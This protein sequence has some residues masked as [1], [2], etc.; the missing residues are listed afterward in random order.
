MC[1]IHVEHRTVV[2]Y[3]RDRGGRAESPA[4]ATV[5]TSSIRI[6]FVFLNPS[7]FRRRLSRPRTNGKGYAAGR[8]GRESTR[9]GMDIPRGYRRGFSRGG[10][11]SSSSE[12]FLWV[13][14]RFFPFSFPFFARD[15]KNLFLCVYE[16]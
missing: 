2:D 11:P 8:G 10:R 1:N 15:I 16:E 4:P 12:R 13:L 6:S 5:H 9:L 3:D 14:N 7:L